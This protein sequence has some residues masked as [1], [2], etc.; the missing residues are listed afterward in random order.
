MP[1]KVLIATRSF[2]SASPRPME[3]LKQAG[4]KLVYADMSLEMT[5]ERLIDLLKGVAGA[6]IG[7]VPM[8]AHVLEN[9]PDL[10]VIS[11]HGVGVDHID[12]DAAVERGITVTNCPGAN[13]ASVADLTIGLMIAVA[14]KIPLAE[15]NLR[16]DAWGRILGS[17]LFQ[18]TLGVVG[19]G[20]IGLGVAK[21]ALGFEMSILVYDPCVAEIPQ[22]FPH[23]RF[24]SFEDVLR[25]SDY[26]SLHTPLNDAT[27]NMIGAA[28][29]AAMKK[30]A[31]LINTAR[32]GLVDE[33][34]L[35]EALYNRQIA[36]AA[37]DCFMNEPPTDSPL[38]EL[39]N[40]VMTPHIGMHTN[41]SIE[42]VG[43]LAA[44]NVVNI[45][46]G[47]EPLSRVQP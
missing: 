10:K 27:L 1:H 20:H 13:A 46:N 7:I 30:E 25:Y 19:L 14:R 33:Q 11:A 17:E 21:R 31:Y 2:G 5:E 8:T 34:A 18:K 41:E 12:L 36:G 38:L 45:L 43:M 15:K 24:A 26:V 28:E 9:A 4:F 44:Q 39:D 40:I 35:Y 37:L 32:G 16:Q 42:R 47:K 3:V 22:G 6:I 23:M 29:L